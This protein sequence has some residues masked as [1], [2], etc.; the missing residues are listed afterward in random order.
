MAC[1]FN[2]YNKSKRLTFI[3]LVKR[4]HHFENINEVQVQKVQKTKCT[5]AHIF[6]D[7][8]DKDHESFH[9]A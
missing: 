3:V 1:K 2:K 9:M 6:Q 8:N 7:Q 5:V 4:A